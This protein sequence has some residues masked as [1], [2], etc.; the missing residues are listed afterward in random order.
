MPTF[1]IGHGCLWG[2]E[3]YGVAIVVIGIPIVLSALLSVSFRFKLHLNKLFRAIISIVGGLSGAIWIQ[4]V[5]CLSMLCDG[6]DEDNP[7]IRYLLQFFAGP[8]CAVACLEWCGRVEIEHVVRGVP[9]AMPV[10]CT[11]EWHNGVRAR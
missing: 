5:P 11:A 9:V 6:G 3:R 4:F 1:V 10:T 2:P 8:V 7:E